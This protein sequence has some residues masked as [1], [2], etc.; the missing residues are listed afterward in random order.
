MK[1]HFLAGFSLILL[2]M[3]AFACKKLKENYG[4]RATGFIGEERQI[5]AKNAAACLQSLLRLT[6][7]RT[8]IRAAYHSN[9]LSY[10]VQEMLAAIANGETDGTGFDQTTFAKS[11]A[12][13][14]ELVERYGV[15]NKYPEPDSNLPAIAR[16]EDLYG[17]FD[18]DIHNGI[19]LE[20]D[21]KEDTDKYG[22]LWY[23]K[24]QS[25]DLI[26]VINFWDKD[27][28]EIRHG[29]EEFEQ[30]QAT[31]MVRYF[32][33]RLMLLHMEKASASALKNRDPATTLFN[34]SLVEAIPAPENIAEHLANNTVETVPDLTS[35]FCVAGE[36][37]F[38]SQF[39]YPFDLI[40]EF[41]EVLADASTQKAAVFFNQNWRTEEEIQEDITTVMASYNAVCNFSYNISSKAF[42]R[43]P[44]AA[45]VTF[46]QENFPKDIKMGEPHR[47]LVKGYCANYS[48]ILKAA[49]ATA[50]AKWWEIHKMTYASD[51]VNSLIG[52]IPVIG[53][54][55]SL[56]L[57]LATYGSR[58]F[59][60]DLTA[61]IQRQAFRT[62]VL[63]GQV[64]SSEDPD[65][66]S[67]R[68]SV[69]AAEIE[70]QGK[71]VE[72]AMMAVITPVVWIL[73]KVIRTGFHGAISAKNILANFIASTQISGLRTATT[74][75]MHRQMADVMFGS[76]R[77]FSN[78]NFVLKI[79]G[80][81]L[82][83]NLRPN[84]FLYKLLHELNIYQIAT[85]KNINPKFVRDVFTTVATK[86]KHVDEGAIGYVMDP[87]RPNYNYAMS[88]VYSWFDNMKATGSEQIQYFKKSC[89]F[90]VEGREIDFGMVCPIF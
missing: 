34:K 47:Y 26:G 24:I 14:I 32:V 28:E 21:I 68:E 80:N 7:S 81:D 52:F 78:I 39:S 64:Q 5:E 11:S 6:I 1:K 57:D 90:D 87:M 55:A 67:G 10:Q 17:D 76:N 46:N 53:S 25:G 65:F 63:S 43:M 27:R 22:Q 82:P 37:S 3:F 48:Y 23:E 75:F 20:N 86:F 49:E 31:A 85:E 62:M 16:Y 40:S 42:N 35:R 29:I 19:C 9:V 56:A 4:S 88:K 69:L 66:I 8:S 59:E 18:A 60:A 89:G 12:V 30:L 58:M 2:S 45:L 51:V 77:L 38:L 50:N 83:F 72:A 33:T 79:G 71:R 74:S 41:E 84:R 73:P 44:I 54:G 70:A 13:C 61:S 36:N 15:A